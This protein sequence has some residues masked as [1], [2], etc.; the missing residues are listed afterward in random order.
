VRIAVVG[1]GISALASAWLLSQSHRVD[2]FEEDDRL[3]GHTCTVDVH[4]DGVDMAVDTGFMVF[5]DRTYPNLIG[6]FDHLGVE[7]QRSTMSFSVRCGEDGLE[8]SS[9]RLVGVFAQPGNAFRA[10]MWALMYDAIRL[11]R[12]A[13]GLL[14]DP[15]LADLTLGE[16][17]IREG[18]SDSF[19]HLYLVPMVAAIWSAPPGEM[20]EFPAETFLRFADNHG[21]LHITGKPR[22]RTVVGGAR[23][24]AQKLAAGIS[25]DVCAGL[26]VTRVS[27]RGDGVDVE[28]VSGETRGFDAIVLGCHADQALALL[29]DPSDAEQDILGAF[30]Y[31]PNQAYL[32]LDGSFLPRAPLARA[33]WNYHMDDCGDLGSTLSVTYDLTRLQGLQAKT[34]V[35]LSLNPLRLPDPER[36]IRVLEFS[37]PVFDY[38]SISAQSRVQEIQ[39]VRRTWFCGAWRRYGFHEDG[40]LSAV[41]VARDFG[42]QAPWNVPPLPEEVGVHEEVRQPRRD[43]G[44]A[45]G[46]AEGGSRRSPRPRPAEG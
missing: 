10:E 35:L 11:S 40:L 36:T 18:Y 31:Q 22:W 16:L 34:P 1:S 30:S 41:W 20:L 13:E 17:L 45:A 9:R 12:D 5:N 46:R 39:G 4:V 15:A 7:S 23:R 21:L 24:Y 25:G 33:S 26:G 6:L 42:V 8:W 43:E 32:H 27:R 37:H 29:A 44:R 3:G 14:A 38:A 2:V 19:T 28:L